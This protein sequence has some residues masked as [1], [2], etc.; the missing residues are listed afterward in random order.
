M[1]KYNIIPVFRLGTVYIYILAAQHHTEIENTQQV[2]LP[3]SA[4]KHIRSTQVQGTLRHTLGKGTCTHTLSEPDLLLLTIGT[5][6][7]GKMMFRWVYTI[8]TQYVS[9]MITICVFPRGFQWAQY[10]IYFLQQGTLHMC[11]PSRFSMG[12][13]WP[14]LLPATR[15][16]TV[17]PGYMDI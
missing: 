8:T 13:V 6:I 12:L 10:L 5:W 9:G 11:L 16:T 15:D 1:Y 17:L 3:L 4:T 2:A 7:Y 14:H